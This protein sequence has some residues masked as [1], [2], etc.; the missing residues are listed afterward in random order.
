MVGNNFVQ[1]NKVSGLKVLT[2]LVPN[3]NATYLIDFTAT[4]TIMN[5]NSG[6]MPVKLKIT[7]PFEKPKAFSVPITKN[8]T[9]DYKNET[10]S[11]TN[12]TET[13]SGNSTSSSSSNATSN[14][15]SD[16]NS[17][18]DSG[19]STDSNSTSDD[20]STSS[21]DSDSSSTGSVSTQSDDGTS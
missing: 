10:T 20:N 16:S 5:G 6:T 2:D 1:W 11:A 15:S 17:T 4:V 14:S 19:N 9:Q 18:S 7:A 3:E 13:D 21:S 8:D 12:D